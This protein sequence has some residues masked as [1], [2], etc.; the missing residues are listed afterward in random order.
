MEKINNAVLTYS[1]ANNV[2]DDIQSLVAMQFLPNCNAFIDRDFINQEKRE[3]KLIGN[4]YW[5]GNGFDPQDNIKMLPLAMHIAKENIKLDWFRKNQ[6]I[7]CRDTYTRDFLLKNEIDAYFSGCLTL[8]LPEYTGERKNRIVIVGN[9]PNW[10]KI[11]FPPKT[12]IL[13]TDSVGRI[14]DEDLRNPLKRFEYAKE[15]LEIYRTAS[16]VIS[17]KIHAIFPCI[18]MGTPVIP[19]V[20]PSNKNRL[21]GYNIPKHYTVDNIDLSGDLTRYKIQK[22]NEIIKVLKE[23][24]TEFALNK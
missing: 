16:L 12:E 13:I 4:G 5:D 24:A 19:I 11:N 17:R 14:K 20:A 2:G 23:K 10:Q 22:P 21:S 15:M 3:L 18:A 8:T 7:G 9:L 1:N 6:P